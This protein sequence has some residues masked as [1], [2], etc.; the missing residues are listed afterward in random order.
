MAGILRKIKG[1]RLSKI[2]DVRAYSM[3]LMILVFSAGLFLIM[4]QEVLGV[5]ELYL[6]G[7]IKSYDKEKGLI[8]VDVRSESCRGIREFK[9]PESVRLELDPSLI[10]QKIDFFI[11]S[12][13]CESGKV[14]NMFLGRQ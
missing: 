5:D 6:S 7:I 13:R 9:V 11:N 12:S 14:Y 8:W 3:I 1:K 10:G 4:C 2:K